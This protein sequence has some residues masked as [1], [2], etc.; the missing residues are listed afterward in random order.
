M[1]ADL[2]TVVDIVLIAQRTIQ[3]TLATIGVIEQA[4]DVLEAERIT[5]TTLLTTMT[6]IEDVLE[7]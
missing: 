5:Q 7:A 3:T 1:R 6:V 4:E 2:E